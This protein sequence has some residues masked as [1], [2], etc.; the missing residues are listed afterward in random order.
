MACALSGQKPESTERR[1]TIVRSGLLF[2]MSEKKRKKIC[3]I[4]RL[5]PE[6]LLWR[7]EKLQL[8]NHGRAETH[9]ES[10]AGAWIA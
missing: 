3:D 10:T 1:Y 8:C 6:R 5:D 4:R 9:G 7:R 2:V